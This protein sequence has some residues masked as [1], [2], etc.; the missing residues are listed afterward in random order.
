MKLIFL[1]LFT[2]YSFFSISQNTNVAGLFPT[3]DHSGSLT[4]KLE[5]GIYYFG[6]FPFLNLNSQKIN[7]SDKFKLIYLEHSL[8]YNFSKNF[9]FTGSYLF[10]K[11]NVLGSNYT[12]ENR[13][14]G[15]LR[16]KQIFPLITLQHR[17]RYDARFIENRFTD[18]SPFTS[19]V[20]YLIGLEKNLSPKLY[21]SAYE[22]LFFSTSK[23]V[24]PIYNE[25]WAYIGIGKKISD[26]NKIEMGLLYVSW[27]LG[28]KS[29]L[30]QFYGQLTWINQLNFRKDK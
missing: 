28:Y 19:R 10:Q 26:K 9:Y 1:F 8:T 2:F 20:R 7:E 27:S 16:Y 22:E 23:N 17:L 18:Q 25:N 30:N 5:Y 11:E 21:I 12:N 4:S 14:Y 15:Q 29:W 13:F 24:N 6:A 3:I